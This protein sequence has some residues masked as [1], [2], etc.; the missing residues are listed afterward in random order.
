M[1]VKDPA[2]FR[3]RDHPDK[4]KVKSCPAVNEKPQGYCLAELKEKKKGKESKG[5]VWQTL[6]FKGRLADSG[7]RM[8]PLYFIGWFWICCADNWKKNK[9][10][11]LKAG[12]PI[13]SKFC[14]CLTRWEGT[15]RSSLGARSLFSYLHV[16]TWFSFPG[17]T[18]SASCS[19]LPPPKGKEKGPECINRNR[20]LCPGFLNQGFKCYCFFDK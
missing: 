12:Y 2:S 4:I 9:A 19:G 18:F 15:S 3:V 6:Q 20:G 10:F 13:A 11:L 8:G 17:W 14:C 5:E 16:C 7:I 1:D